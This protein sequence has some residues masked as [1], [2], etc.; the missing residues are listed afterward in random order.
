MKSSVKYKEFCPT[1]A[2]IHQKENQNYQPLSWSARYTRSLRTVP[3]PRPTNEIA[4][5][6]ITS[7]ITFPAL[8]HARRGFDQG[9][10]HEI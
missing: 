4:V 5:C 1:L 8:Q 3:I 2:N 6:H 9:Q 10:N 7:F